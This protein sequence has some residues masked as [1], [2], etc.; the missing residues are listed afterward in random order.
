MEVMKAKALARRRCDRL[1]REKDDLHDRCTH[2]FIVLGRIL[3]HLGFAVVLYVNL[4]LSAFLECTLFLRQ[5]SRRLLAARQ[6]LVGGASRSGPPGG[7]VFE[8]RG[9]EWCRSIRLWSKPKPTYL[10]QGVCHKE[11]CVLLEKEFLM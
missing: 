3:R 9:M 1:V 8:R 10:P 4:D 11:F 7:G 2:K 6:V 5:S